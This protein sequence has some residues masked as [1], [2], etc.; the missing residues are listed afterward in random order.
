MEA[1]DAAKLSGLLS[2]A[3]D[4]TRSAQVR[5][6]AYEDVIDYLFTHVPGCQVQ[7][8][9]LNTFQ[10]EEVDLSV[11]NFRL[12]NG[13]RML[14]DIFLIECKNWSQKVDSSAVAF[15]GMKIRH[16]GCSLGVLVAANGVTG[17]PIDKTAAM[18]QGALL[19]AEGIK[20][21]VLTSEDLHNFRTVEDIVGTLHRRF[22]DLHAA[23]TFTL[24]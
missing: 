17:D 24:A 20:M 2:V 7:R 16:R 10:S 15:F 13:L 19:L 5:G 11:G 4:S 22:L 14:P 6:R 3:E 23:G 21:L 9:S 18:Q 1:F 8:N 12:E